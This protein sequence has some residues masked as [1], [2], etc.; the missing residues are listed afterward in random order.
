MKATRSFRFVESDGGFSTVGMV[1]SLLLT[2][3]LVFTTA[4]VYRIE[5]A[6]AEIQEVADAAALAAENEVAEFMVIARVSDAVVLTLSLTGIVCFGLGAAALC[7]PATA[8]VSGHLISA[9]K[10]LLEA[11]NT[12]SQNA[13]ASLNALQ[14]SLPFVAAA[15]AALVARENNA[16]SLPA[17]YIAVAVLSPF[18]GKEIQVH[19]ADKIQELEDSIDERAEDV[20]ANAKLAEEAAKKAN[21]AKEVAFEHDCGADPN[22]CMYERADTLSILDGTQNP[23]YQSI[24][25][26]SFSV[27][28]K[29]AQAYYSARY[30]MENPGDYSSVED[31]ARSALRKRFYAYA[32]EKLALGY[33]YEDGDSFEAFFPRLPKNT[34]EMRETSLYT[35]AAYP[36]TQNSDGTRTMHSWSGCPKAGSASSYGSIALME[37]GGFTT[38]PA[39][40]FTAASM[41]KVA[42]ASTSIENGF[43][44]HYCIVADKAAEYEKERKKGEEPSRA[45][46]SQAEKWFD[47]CFEA[48][49]ETADMRIDAQPPGSFG[50]IAIV[51]NT[52]SSD[53]SAGLGSFAS[54]DA[55][56]GTRVAVSG[57]TLLEDSSNDSSTII[58]S[59][60]DEISSSNALAGMADVAMDC[61]SGMLTAY[62]KGQ[63]ALDSATSDLAAKIPFASASGLGTWAS[64]TFRS[65]VEALGL[66]PARLMALKPVLVNTGHIAAKD[67]GPLASGYTSAK[68]AASNAAEASAVFSGVLSGVEYDTYLDELFENDKIR[69]A[70]IKPFGENGPEF[71][72]SI[73]IPQSIKSFGVS[74]LEGF[75]GVIRSAVPSITGERVWQ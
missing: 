28:L 16:S 1:I 20:S 74:V 35:E 69:I 61:W 8:T 22:Y 46:K 47:Q 38:C 3:A 55:A 18:E 63:D 21:E 17:I 57:A 48:L 53:V 60:F 50:C 33:V 71:P 27:A 62:D 39:C 25:A 36:V 64:K 4:Q 12:F 32:C 37:S 65:K 15:N 73:A 10:S 51:V 67:D 43:E 72:L 56:L 41:G 52:A 2:C 49:K 31:K 34:S 19:A 6:S 7:T 54:G 14:K 29:R 42:A 9:G 30:Q 13:A 66:Q 40:D 5:S 75:L 24:D 44:Y 23:L 58:S 45:V 59:F 70:V 68:Q 26:W 11:R